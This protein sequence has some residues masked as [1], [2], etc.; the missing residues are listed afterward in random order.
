MTWSRTY[1]FPGFGAPTKPGYGVC[2]NITDSAV[3][4]TVTANAQ[5]DKTKNVSRFARHIK[6]ACKTMIQLAEDAKAATAAAPNG[7]PTD[8][9]SRAKL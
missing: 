7:V 1:D 3:L 8:H 5:S 4:M 6:W 2:Y 9:A